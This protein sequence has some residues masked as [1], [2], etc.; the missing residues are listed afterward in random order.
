MEKSLR[1]IYNASLD[2]SPS[3]RMTGKENIGN[4]LMRTDLFKRGQSSQAQFKGRTFQARISVVVTV[5][6]DD[7]GVKILLSDLAKQTI[8]ADEIIVVRAESYQNCSRGKGRNIGI[9]KAKNKIIAVTDAGCRPHKNWLEKL[10]SPL[11]AKKGDAAAGFYKTIAKTDLQ[12]AIAPY[13]GVTLGKNY[14]P[15]SRSIAFTKSAWGKVGGYPENAESGA[16][17]LEFARRL[18]DTPGIKV[19][20]A[21]Q[22]LVDWEV[23]NNL[24]DFA[25]DIYKHTMGNFEVKYWPHILRN[26]SVIL[27]WIIFVIYPWMLIAYLIW[28]LGKVRL[29]TNQIVTP[30]NG[31]RNDEVN[32]IAT[33]MTVKILIWL[34]VVQLVADAAVIAT[35]LR[36]LLRSGRATPKAT[37]LGG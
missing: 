10:A 4:N 13:L 36:L 18:G 14:L 37:H 25:K 2:S 1:N 8:K 28:I 17:D 35:L 23:P 29:V 15:A 20:Q 27:R 12:K 26:L 22:A 32:Q 30:R 9:K 34:P 24:I 5:K 19:I 6:N 21:P 3:L 31:T 7:A 11:F 16:E 33:A